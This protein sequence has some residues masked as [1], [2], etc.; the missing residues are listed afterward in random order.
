M[1]VSKFK[2]FNLYNNLIKLENQKK[3][4]L[5]YQTL[6]NNNNNNNANNNNNFNNNFN[7]NN[8]YKY[9]IIFL[10]MMNLFHG[11]IMI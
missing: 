11:S 2:I 6:Y 1:I 3:L 5:S 7:N 9:K 8:N 10:V 4:I